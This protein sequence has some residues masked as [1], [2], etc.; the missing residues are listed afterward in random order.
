MLKPL[1][2]KQFY[3]WFL[4]ACFA[5]AI[6]DVCCATSTSSADDPIESEAKNLGFLVF[7]GEYED[8]LDRYLKAARY[9]A[10]DVV[11]R[12]TSDCPCVD[13]TI[14]DSIIRLREKRC[15]LCVKQHASVMANRH[16]CR[17]V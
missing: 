5:K 17:S 9:T 15:R 2:K 8:V 3:K 16:G 13:P 4:S 10:A 7:R 1:G 11:V 6:D 14:A 12:V